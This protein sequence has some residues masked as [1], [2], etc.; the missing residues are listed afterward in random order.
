MLPR[1]LLALIVGL[2]CWLAAVAA[3]LDPHTTTLPIYWLPADAKADGNLA[4]WKGVPAAITPEQF[5]LNETDVPLTPS[6]DFA[7]SVFVG[8]KRNSTDLFILVVVR[9][10]CILGVE[11]TD[12][13]FGDCMEL[14]L[15]YGREARAKVDPQWW[16]DANKWGNVQERSQFAFL[17]QTPSEPGKVFRAP[18]SLRNWDVDYA[19]VPVRDGF[20]YEVRVDGA[21]V[22]KDLKLNE[23]PREIGIEFMLRAVDYPTILDGAG[24]AN[25]RGYLR[26]FGNWMTAFNPSVYGGLSTV[27][28]EPAGDAVPA[29]TLAA[30]YGESP[31]LDTL[32]TAVKEGKLDGNALAELLYWV[33]YQGQVIDA[34]LVRQLMASDTPRL[35]EVCLLLMLDPAQD[36]DARRAAVMLAY[37]HL[38]TA[39]ALELTAANMLQ[40][41]I[42]K[43]HG[44]ALVRLLRHP[45]PTVAY[46]AAMALSTT[47][48]KKDLAAFQQLYPDMLASLEKDPAQKSR[49]PVLRAFMQPALDGMTFRL[50]PPPPPKAEAVRKLEAKNTDLTRVF[51]A[52]NN[53]VYNGASLLRAWPAT[54]PKELWRYEIGGG[55][56]AVTEAGGWTFALGM[57]GDK[58]TAFSFDA[59]TGKLLWQQVLT[60]KKF[61]YGAGCPL[62]DG[63][64]RVY[65]SLP[66]AVVCLKTEDGSVIWREEKAYGGAEF[67]SPLLAGD[68]LLVPG[69][70]LTAVDKLTGQVRWQVKGP[71][72][73]PASPALQMLNGVGQVILAVGSDTTA[74]LWGVSLKDG[75]VF[76]KYPVR[77][78]YGLCTSPVV[79]GSR[80]L[81]SGG[82]AGRE[83]FTELQMA[84]KDGKIKA[85]PAIVRN[86][87]QHNYAH[88]MSVWNGM[89]FGY[90]GGGLE[91]DNVKTGD[92]YWRNKNKW[93]NGLQLVV[94]DGLLL[95]QNG[96]DMVLAEANKRGYKELGRFTLPINPSNQQPTLANGRLYVRGESW[97][98]CYGVSK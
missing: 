19:S 92:T 8:R 15:D 5:K 56:A 65:F 11:S 63:A 81:I 73:S 22:M 31:T 87:V 64:D 50:A 13:V 91:C 49:V 58:P 7:P 57:K 21:S 10:R 20:A 36:R 62:L 84:V 43:D 71:V 42:G 39:S 54:G 34:A 28:R 90:G 26:L 35:R 89:I 95:V 67:S 86:D 72:V 37:N 24:W 40:K 30:L 12:W 3:P 33:A 48:N 29:Q 93:N 61:S 53:T 82:E 83:C 51:A 74:E 6:D 66:G 46:T 97:V 17:P 68:L 98:V 52:D 47:G 16:K 4:K 2:C 96:K 60:D 25:H 44:D 69:S 45:D 9:D 18:N 23:L 59:A 75:E 70:T 76:W 32:R 41:A 38:D 78:V 14:Y 1:L 27:P 85:Y 80:V 79:D 77:G 55:L 88:T 94:A